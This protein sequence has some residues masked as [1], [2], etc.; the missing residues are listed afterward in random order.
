[1]FCILGFTKLNRIECNSL[2]TDLD[3]KLNSEFV[4]STKVH[5]EI[6]PIL[7]SFEREEDSLNVDILLSLQTTTDNNNFVY[8]ELELNLQ[9]SQNKTT[10]IK[11]VNDGPIIKDSEKGFSLAQ[12][13]SSS[14]LIIFTSIEIL[15]YL[16]KL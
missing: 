6:S 7:E 4:Q 1:V 14:K 13:H 15:S 11:P 10:E 2:N 8:A 9:K 5:Q 12:N 16:I 3:L